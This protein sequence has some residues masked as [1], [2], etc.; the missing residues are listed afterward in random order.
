MK[1]I[2]VDDNRLTLFI[3]KKIVENS[4]KKAKVICY[5][6][7]SKLIE[8]IQTESVKMPDLVFSD[9]NMGTLNGIDVLN[10]FEVASLN[11]NSSHKPNF[12]LV[13]GETD[14]A[15]ITSNI[16][17]SLLASYIQKPMTKEKLEYICSNR[18]AS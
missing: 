9:Y 18:I 11:N 8:D 7:P 14:V 12:I 1:I 16:D 17:S 15:E 13:S 4:F 6:D 10:A 2:L 3:H 5:S